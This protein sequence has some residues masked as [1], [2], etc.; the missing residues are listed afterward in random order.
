MI[1]RWTPKEILS[2][3]FELGYA[4]SHKKRNISIQE[5]SWITQINGISWHKFLKVE[6]LLWL[7][8]ETF[9]EKREKRKIPAKNTRE[10]C[11]QSKE[12]RLTASQNTDIRPAT[13]RETRQPV[14]WVVLEAIFPNSSSK[15]FSLVKPETLSKVPNN[16][17]YFIKEWSFILSMRYLFLQLLIAQKTNTVLSKLNEL[18]DI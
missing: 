13:R 14:T 1:R 5:L 2:V 8:S 6:S 11:M 16:L 15:K 12:K 17:V 10:K 18:E 4:T 7:E 9:G 3:I